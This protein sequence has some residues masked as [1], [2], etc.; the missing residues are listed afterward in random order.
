MQI[1]AL[2]VAG[3]LSGH[4]PPPPP[5]VGTSPCTSFVGDQAKT[6]IWLR[7]TYRVLGYRAASQTTYAGKLV[8][9]G[10]EGSAVLS[11]ARSTAEAQSTGS[12]R[13]VHC[14]PDAVTQLEV[15][16][17]SGREQETL[18]CVP[19]ND[20]DNMDRLS[21]ARSLSDPAGDIEVWYRQAAT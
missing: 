1:A 15:K 16:F 18:Y 7:G 9:T 4:I 21:C 3:A 12:A 14:G 6:V 19:H 11:L 13:L 2:L 20:Y 5:P 10:G 8:A 17:G